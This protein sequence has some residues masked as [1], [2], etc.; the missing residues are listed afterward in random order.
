M[1]ALMCIESFNLFCDKPN[2]PCYWD[3]SVYNAKNGG[4]LSNPGDFFTD[5]RAK[6]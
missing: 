2:T 6:S 1:K 4:F 5:A 3:K